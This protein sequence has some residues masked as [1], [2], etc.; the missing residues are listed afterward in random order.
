MSSK[1]SR[2][3]DRKG[4]QLPTPTLKVGRLVDHK[5]HS[6]GRTPIDTRDTIPS[7]NRFL[8][9]NSFS[10]PGVLIGFCEGSKSF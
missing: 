8:S 5:D 10:P 1:I 7:T 2:I 3:K 6:S 9:P 4:F